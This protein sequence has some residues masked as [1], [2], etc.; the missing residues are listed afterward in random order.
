M[1]PNG[2]FAVLTSAIKTI[3]KVVTSLVKFQEEFL[4]KGIQYL[5]PLVLKQV[6]EDVEMHESTISRVTTNKYMHCPQ[7]IFELKYFFNAGIPRADSRGQEIPSVTVM[8]MIRE[9][10]AQEDG[11][12]PLK[13]QEIVARLRNKDILIARRTVA[14]YRAELNI[15]SA[16][17][18]KRISY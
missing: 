1:V 7:G 16:S 18:R 6:A 17:Q 15:A 4:E 9:M 13:D 8:E 3:V 10:V 2:L 5:R 12:R 11:S 14:K